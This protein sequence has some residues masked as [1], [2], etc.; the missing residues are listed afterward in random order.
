MRRVYT[1]LPWMLWCDAVMGL[2][3]FAM[4]VASSVLL[5]YGMVIMDQILY[6]IIIGKSMNCNYYFRVESCLNFYLKLLKRNQHEFMKKLFRDVI[7][8]SR[9]MQ[10]LRRNSRLLV[11]SIYFLSNLRSQ[12]SQR[13]KD[14][15]DLKDLKN[16]KDLKDLCKI[17]LRSP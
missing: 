4:V 1:V 9:N 5:V 17:S 15:K 3:M 14:S 16:P 12:R 13:S 8:T 10:R 2:E 11:L 6:G 7:E